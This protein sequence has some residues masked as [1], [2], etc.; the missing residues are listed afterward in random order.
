VGHLA[1]CCNEDESCQQ[2]QWQSSTNPKKN[3]NQKNKQQQPKQKQQQQALL[4]NNDVR[5]NNGNNAFPSQLMSRECSSSIG[6]MGMLDENKSGK[7]ASTSSSREKVRDLKSLGKD[8]GGIG[9]SG[10]IT[11]HAQKGPQQQ[12]ALASDSNNNSATTMTTTTIGPPRPPPSCGASSTNP[13]WATLTIPFRQFSHW[14]IDSS[15][16][17][18]CRPWHAETDNWRGTKPY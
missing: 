7:G 17:Y 1:S 2:W 12:S 11:R 13:E 9:L 3:S 6:G 5:N 16:R 8:A 4:C 10:G 18:W 15:P 14:A